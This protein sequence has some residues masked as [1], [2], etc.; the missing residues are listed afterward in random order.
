MGENRIIESKVNISR[1]NFLGDESSNGEWTVG[2]VTD[3]D[4]IMANP[5]HC[6]LS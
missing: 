4:I 2:E 5:R 3:N 1:H 6:I